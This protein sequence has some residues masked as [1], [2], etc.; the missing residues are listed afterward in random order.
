MRT[1]IIRI[2]NNRA[3]SSE[4]GNLLIVGHYGADFLA[5]RRTFSASAR[6][7]PSSSPAQYRRPMAHCHGVLPH[8]GPGAGNRRFDLGT[9]YRAVTNARLENAARIS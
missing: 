7:N 1:R 3:A 8:H 5:A 4:S 6:I 9:G 2:R